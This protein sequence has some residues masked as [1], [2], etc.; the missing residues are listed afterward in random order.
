MRRLIELIA[1]ARMGSGFRWLLASDWSNQL[2]DGIS[3]AA[4][5]LLIASQTKNPSLVILATLLGRAPWFLFGLF[6][7]WIADR[8]DRRKLV[9]FADIA[10]TVVLVGLAVVIFTDQVSVTLVLVAMF[11]IGTS[12][13]FA[14][15]AFGTLMPMLVPPEDLGIANA[16]TGFG[17]KGINELIGPPIG[18]ALFVGGLAVPFLAQAVLVSLAAVLISRITVGRPAEVLP[19]AGV[20]ADVMEGVHW[21]WNNPPIR[22]LTLTVVLFNLTF[23][24]MWPILVLYNEQQLG[25]DEV[26]FGLLLS[27]GA[28]GGVLGAMAYG[29]LER[30]ASLGSLMR[31]SLVVETF[32]HLGLG[33][34]TTQFLSMAILFAFGFQSSIWGTTASAVRQ[35]AVPENLQGRVGA[36]YF[37][38]VFGG[39]VFG[40][41]IGAVIA[42]IWGVLA[43]FWFGFVG[44]AIMLVIIWRE[45]P[46]IAHADPLNQHL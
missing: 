4:G 13:V 29:A 27:A 31:A 30:R 44:S 15:S 20:R 6:A 17:R 45:L 36:V 9:A 12:E 39:L 1:P 25:Q 16:R 2:G 8:Y 22:T 34:S 24:A 37:L 10:R 28:V 7:G 21:L 41:A 26:G 38:G 5:P 32:V 23:G 18:A 11:L 19:S 33:L 46:H 42:G 40:N 35:R 3:L 43:P 14:D